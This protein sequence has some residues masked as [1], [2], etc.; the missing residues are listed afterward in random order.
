MENYYTFNVTAPLFLH[1]DEPADYSDAI[2]DD[3]IMTHKPY[4][5]LLEDVC[6]GFE[7]YHNKQ[8]I[9]ALSYDRE[10]RTIHATLQLLISP[11]STFF[12]EGPESYADD[13]KDYILSNSFEDG[14][15]GGDGASFILNDKYVGVFD[16][17]SRKHVHVTLISSRPGPP[18]E[19]YEN[20]WVQEYKESAH[21]FKDAEALA[22]FKRLLYAPDDEKRNLRHDLTVHYLRRE[23]Y[24][25]MTVFL[26]IEKSPFYNSD[27]QR[28]EAFKNIAAQARRALLMA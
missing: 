6:F 14:C 2:L 12:P 16:I 1:E 26:R 17:R 5:A 8:C 24:G 23:I 22:N 7:S 27:E 3:Y 20:E 25:L 10:T 4:E 11:G 13:L 21:K 18:Q 19:A 15:Y 28:L 9:Q